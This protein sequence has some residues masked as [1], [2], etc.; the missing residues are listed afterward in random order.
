MTQTPPHIALIIGSTREQSRT[1]KSVRFVAG[2]LEA[3]HGAS[4]DVID[5]RDLVLKFPGQEGAEDFEADLTQRVARAD[6]VLLGTPEYHGS[7]SA[8]L[9]AFIDCLGYPSALEGKP[10]AMIGVAAGRMGAAKS[11]EHLAGVCLH[12]G[13]MVLPGAVSISKA[14][15]AFDD[16]GACVDPEIAAELTHLA[17]VLVEAARGHLLFDSNLEHSAQEHSPRD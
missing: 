12:V 15:A 13:A 8:V 14:Y 11:L 5:P 6:A 10:I 17:L 1:A 4:V 9:K 2:C 7:F 16:Q 3:Q